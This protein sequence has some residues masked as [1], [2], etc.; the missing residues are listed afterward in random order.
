M[1]KA[2]PTELEKSKPNEVA[3]IDYGADVGAGMENADA[4]TF[5]I[6]FLTVLQSNSPQCV[7]G[8]SKYMEDA[9]PGM[10]LN[11]VTN[12][13]YDGKEGVLFVPSHYRRVF[14]CWGPRQGEG[15]GFKGEFNADQI[16][17]MRESRQI[18]EF[19]GRLYQPL[20]DGSVNPKKCTRYADTRLHY[21]LT[22]DEDTGEVQS[23]LLSL[24]STQI[25]KS[26]QL[27]SA[28]SAVRVQLADGRKVPAPTFA[29]IVRV[30][31][32][33]ES[34]DQG[35]WFGVKMAIVSKVDDANVYAAGKAFHDQVVSG[36]ATAQHAE[37]STAGAAEE[38]F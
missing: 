19:E 12:K 30:T 7:E 5:A 2:K 4:D 38:A 35:N 34:N 1:A 18:V 8:E 17:K 36:R 31:T 33:P 15:A 21:G 11:T 9:R 29:N 3:Q 6:P 25:K 10:I 16:A 14:L 22:I 13:L 20:Q 23:V 24:S 37:E 26:K 28:L 27:M 32:V